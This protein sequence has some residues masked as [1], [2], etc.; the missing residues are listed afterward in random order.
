MLFLCFFLSFSLLGNII[1][2]LL[3]SLI[4]IYFFQRSLISFISFIHLFISI[5]GSL[6]SHI[7]FLSRSFSSNQF[8]LRVTLINFPGLYH[9]LKSA[10]SI[11]HANVKL[12]HFVQQKRML[13]P[14]ETHYLLLQHDIIALWSV[15]LSVHLL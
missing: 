9:S 14:S 7:F 6:I 5:S 13:I 10:V 3:S 15:K 8:S 4:K 2:L 12:A 11:D 1:E